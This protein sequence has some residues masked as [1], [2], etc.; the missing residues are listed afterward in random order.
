MTDSSDIRGGGILSK[1]KPPP[2]VE[3][4]VEQSHDTARE[5]G[6]LPVLRNALVNQLSVYEEN[7]QRNGFNE[8]EYHK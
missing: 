5:I 6:A 2:E 7:R 4:C 8:A 1:G 3:P